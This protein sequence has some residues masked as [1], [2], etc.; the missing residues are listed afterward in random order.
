MFSGFLYFSELKWY[1]TLAK[2]V[3]SVRGGRVLK[4]Q[5]HV[6]FYRFDFRKDL[7]CEACW[8]K[9]CVYVCS[10]TFVCLVLAGHFDLMLFFFLL[11]L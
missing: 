7:A 6:Y 11:N 5:Y 3:E 4:T 8:V 9:G 10:L 1:S 2:L